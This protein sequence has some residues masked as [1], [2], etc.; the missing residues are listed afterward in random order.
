M[1]GGRP[2]CSHKSANRWWSH[3]WPGIMGRELVGPQRCKDDFCKVCG[4][5][6]LPWYRRKN[7]AFRNKIIFMHGNVLP[8]AAKNT[9]ASMAAMGIKGEKVMVWPPS[10]P[11]LNPIENL[12]SILKIR[13]RS[14]RV[15]GSLH[16]NSSSGRLF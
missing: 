7:Y 16:L 14:M 3:V 1:V 10:S 6:F 9:S 13:K 15:R 5:H 11:D 4:Y 12:W 8:H 2:P